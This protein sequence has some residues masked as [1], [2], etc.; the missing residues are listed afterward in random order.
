M[1][2]THVYIF[3]SLQFYIS[4]PTPIYRVRGGSPAEA[5]GL[6]TGDRII[7]ADGISFINYPY[8]DAVDV[9]LGEGKTVAE[10]SA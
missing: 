7:E 4:P 6:M 5:A 1:I 10:V 9:L 3:F 2:N 8:E